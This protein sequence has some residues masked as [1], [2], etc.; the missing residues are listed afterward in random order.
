MPSLA[1]DH[2]CL[3]S[4]A[5]SSAA[6]PSQVARDLLSVDLAAWRYERGLAAFATNP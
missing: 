4:V 2:F 5:K 6:W 1:L 3:F